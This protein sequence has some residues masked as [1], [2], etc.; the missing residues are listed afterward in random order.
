MD[1]I[2]WSRTWATKSTTTTSRK[3]LQ[4]SLK[5]S[6]SKRMH[7]LLRA[8]K[9]AEAKPQRRTLASSS[10]RAVSICERDFGDWTIVFGTNLR[11]LSIGLTFCGRTRWQEAEAIRKDFN[12]VLTSQDKKFFLFKAIQ[13]AVSVILFYRTMWL[14]RV[15]SSSTFIQSDVQSIHITS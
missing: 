1:W 15:T 10:T 13:D 5:N 12:I 7:L 4:W 6:R 2:T 11:T 9:K 3:P 8:V 14:L